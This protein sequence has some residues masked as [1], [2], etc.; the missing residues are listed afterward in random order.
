MPVRSK[1][2][3]HSSEGIYLD[4]ASSVFIYNAKVIGS[5]KGKESA[6]V[7]MYS[8]E[9]ELFDQEYTKSTGSISYQKK[10]DFIYI[11]P[12]AYIQMKHQTF[13]PGY[14][15]TGKERAH[16]EEVANEQGLAFRYK[17]YKPEKGNQYEVVL[18]FSDSKS[19]DQPWNM[20][21]RFKEEKY[22]YT[23]SKSNHLQNMPR[24]FYTE[25]TSGGGAVGAFL[26]VG[27]IGVGIS[28]AASE[29]P[30]D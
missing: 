14:D 20:H 3:N 2:Y 10:P 30:Q 4:L 18:V 25:N 26:L 29:E 16:M 11:P 23:T 21:S 28:A 17:T 12:G 15:K 13:K 9:R 6:R 22:H 24:I 27:I 1:V 8:E 7:R 5:M 19:F